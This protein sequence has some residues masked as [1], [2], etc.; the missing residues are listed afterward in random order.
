[1]PPFVPIP[2]RR[3]VYRALSRAVD[4]P[5]L[6]GTEVA[7]LGCVSGSREGRAMIAPSLVLRTSFFVAVHVGLLA[8]VLL[9]P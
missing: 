9:L 2:A 7:P 1:M 5:S 3:D 6:R 4:S 8:G